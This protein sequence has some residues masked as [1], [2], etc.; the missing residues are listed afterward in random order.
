MAEW[1]IPLISGLGREIEAKLVYKVSS[2]IAKAGYYTE[3]PCLLGMCE[4]PR[5]SH[6]ALN[7]CVFKVEIS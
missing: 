1:C 4:F 2:G 6:K 3:K 7:R 5:P